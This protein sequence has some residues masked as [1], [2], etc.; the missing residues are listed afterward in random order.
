M[1]LRHDALDL[2]LSKTLVLGCDRL[3]ADQDQAD[4]YEKSE[5]VKKTL[6]HH[7]SRLEILSAERLRRPMCGK[8]GAFRAVFLFRSSKRLR[9]SMRGIASLN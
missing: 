2:I 9:L 6:T 3:K 7:V 5:R 4:V 1:H 8:P